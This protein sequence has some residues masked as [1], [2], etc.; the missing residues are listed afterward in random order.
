M[1]RTPPLYRSVSVGAGG[2][3]RKCRGKRAERR[4]GG[5]GKES[6]TP[7]S[8]QASI[9]TVSVRKRCPARVHNPSASS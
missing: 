8:S 2:A 5:G 6:S 4:R 3:R 1:Q 7:L 9:S